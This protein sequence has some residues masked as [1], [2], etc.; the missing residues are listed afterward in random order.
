MTRVACWYIAVGAV[1]LVALPFAHAQEARVAVVGDGIVRAGESLDV[2]VTLDKAPN[3]DATIAVIFSL[4]EGNRTLS[5]AGQT[6]LNE[7]VCHVKVYT[8]PAAMGGVYM[9]SRV[10]FSDSASWVDLPHKD[11]VT[12]RLIGNP[13]LIYPTSAEVQVNPSQ[14]QFLRSAA[15]LLQNRLHA[16]KASVAGEEEPH[17]RAAIGRFRS[18]IEAELG[19]LKET[20]TKFRDLGDKSQDKLQQET[21]QV[22]F[23]DLRIGYTEAL[24][25]LSL[26]RRASSLPR[27]VAVS[28]TAELGG[29]Y[30]VTA[31]A[32]F[33]AFE[34]NEL[35]YDFVADNQT[36]EFDLDVNSNPEGAAVSYRRR[37]DP[38][39]QHQNPTNSTIKSLP[40]AIWT[41]RFQKQGYHDREIDFNP[42]VERNRTLTANLEK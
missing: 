5:G 28:Q 8:P 34:L 12:F 16:L 29:K 41:V 3:F 2:I 25:D 1:L 14:I 33:R 31:Q 17:T 7:R 9:L 26:K 21:A 42:F 23:D 38:Y 22:F 18:S 36:L 37:G 6:K 15:I 32:I 4:R 20:E 30:S 40:L 11:N 39:K 35:A 24:H 19:T 13:G 10:Q 27:I